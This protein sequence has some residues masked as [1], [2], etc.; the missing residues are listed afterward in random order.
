MNR[1][2]DITKFYNIE[3]N[4]KFK[5]RSLKSGI[6]FDADYWMDE[7][8]LCGPEMQEDLDINFMKIITGDYE[9]VKK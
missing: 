3:L 9:I 6:I 2:H 7:T 5:I 4:E 1:M 8:G